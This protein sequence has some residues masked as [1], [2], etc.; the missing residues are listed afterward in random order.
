MPGRRLSPIPWTQ[1]W[2]ARSIRANAPSSR[3]R[4]NP[5]TAAAYS[6]L[7]AAAVRQRCQRM[8]ALGRDGKLQHFD[9]ALE[10]LDAAADLSIACTHRSYPLLDVPLH[11]RWRH[12]TVDGE[13][14]WARIEKANP[15]HDAA[16]R[17]R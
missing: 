2:A 8:L 3:P 15:W 4:V 17:A 7:S 5:A 14:R 11:S 1:P 6:L 13:D 10:R 9:V 16:E 12:F